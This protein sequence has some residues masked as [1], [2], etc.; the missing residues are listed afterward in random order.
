[1]KSLVSAAAL[2]LLA[3]PAAASAA[4]VGRI[5]VHLFYETTGRLSDDIATTGFAAF[6]VVIGEGSAEEPA[7]DVV[8]AVEVRATDEARTPL[9]IVVRNEH[10]R[11]LAQR[12]VRGPFY[13]EGGSLWKAVWLE[14]AGCAGPLTITAAIGRSTA[15]ER[16]I[17]ACGE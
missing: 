7:N 15:T 3:M 9:R 10:G 12:T 13:S 8:V 16:V 17:L 2:L 11:I 6:N 5:R 4:E 14:D 1:M